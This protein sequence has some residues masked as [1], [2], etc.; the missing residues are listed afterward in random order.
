MNF[1]ET[2]RNLNEDFPVALQAHVASADA[3]A[4]SARGDHELAASHHKVASDKH[5]TASS[6][7]KNKNVR[8][9][10]SIMS[11]HHADL[12]NFHHT[13]STGSSADSAHPTY[14]GAAHSKVRTNDSGGAITR[15][16]TRAGL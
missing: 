6:V 8:H 10:H 9:Y 5:N 7:T 3:N 1:F 13:A 2:V 4:A 14:A 12:S 11:L 16:S 15:A